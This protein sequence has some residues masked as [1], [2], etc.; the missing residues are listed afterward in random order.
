MRTDSQHGAGLDVSE[1]GAE[2]EPERGPLLLAQD[3][4]RVYAGGNAGGGPQRGQTVPRRAYG[5]LLTAPE[6]RPGQ[7]VT[8]LV[9]AVLLSRG[10]CA[11]TDDGIAHDI[12]GQRRVI[13]HQQCLLIQRGSVTLVGGLPAGPAGR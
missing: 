9:F 2:Y 10:Q 4:A 7:A 12:L 5:Q 6:D 13:E 3:A 1:A 8:C 11:L